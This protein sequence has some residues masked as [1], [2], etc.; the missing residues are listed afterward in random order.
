M[1][2]ILLLEI[3]VEE[4]PPLAVGKTLTQLKAQG[5]KLFDT[6][7]INYERVSSFGSS[8]R[9]VF[10]VEGVADNQRDRT[11]KE[12]G[13]PRSV[14][15]TQSGQLTPE[16][17]AYLRA[18]GAKK[19]DLGIEELTKG[20]YVY[21]KRKIKGKR[22]KKILPHLLVQ[23]IKSLS[24]PK[25]MRWGEGDFSFGR[26]IRSLMALF[27]EEVIRLEVASVPSDRKTRGHPYLSPFTFS[28]R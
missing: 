13:P 19:E 20:D 22:T 7:H 1:S 5:Q 10:W 11:E 21:L 3:G 15:L 2:K 17:R 9:L 14:V 28:I 16:G 23:L 6:S 24:F 27:G 8:R 4:L 18:K 26:P 25:S 12:M